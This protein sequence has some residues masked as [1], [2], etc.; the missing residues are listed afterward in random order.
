MSKS[1]VHGT[2]SLER[3]YPVAPGRVFSAF[4]NAETKARWFVGPEGWKLVER[5]Q[6]FRVGGAEI[7][8][9][10]FPD[11][12]ESRF[13]ARYHVIVENERVVYAYD[14]LV[15]GSLLSVSLVTIE[16]R[17]EKG[18]T[19]LTFTEQGV[20]FGTHDDVAAREQGSSF[21]LAQL[22][23]SLGAK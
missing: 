1:P 23:A 15:S 13:E 8:H 2:F 20:F 21:L 22:G 11:G 16:I 18:E 7:V 12:K 9:G 4:A 5:K 10:R 3:S 19:R 14:M 17:P 6:D